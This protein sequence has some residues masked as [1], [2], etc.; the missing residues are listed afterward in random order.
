MII[1]VIQARMGSTRLPGKVLLP[2]LGRP[3][4]ALQ[5]ERVKR[6]K[7]IDQIVIATSGHPSDLPIQQFA[8]ENGI[9][10]IRGAVDDVLD[11]YYQAAKRTQAEHIVRLTGDCPLSDPEVIDAV[12]R[13]HVRHHEDY[14][15]NVHPPTYPDGLDVEVLTM[16]ALQEAWNNADAASERE[17]VT[18]YF[19]RDLRHV[20]RGNVTNET[21]VS[22]IRLTVDEPEDYEVVKS[23]FEGLVAMG[24]TFGMEDI[25][26]LL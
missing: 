12:V 9:L 4:L 11:R 10:C 1:A 5:I 15:S 18:S 13:Q 14:T 25:I 16:R 21:D 8:Q 23:V 20:E 7:L 2:I 6:A 19:R 26:K 3:M 17:H 24:N 22:H